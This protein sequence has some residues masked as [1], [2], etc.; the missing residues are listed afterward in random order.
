MTRLDFSH[1]WKHF[2]QQRQMMERGLELKPSNMR[3]AHH[4]AEIGAYKYEQR[5]W[6]RIGT[7]P[8]DDYLRF[9]VGKLDYHEQGMFEY[10][11]FVAKQY[12]NKWRG[13][14]W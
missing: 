6:E 9:H 4:P 3:T 14:N 12:G 5:L 1:E 13:I 8:S 10:R 7:K 11:S 2:G